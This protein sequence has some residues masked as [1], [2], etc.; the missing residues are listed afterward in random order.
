MFLHIAICD[1]DPEVSEKIKSYID[2][3]QIA[4]DHD[5]HIDLFADG[6]SLLSSENP[7]EYSLIFLDVE[8]PILSGIETARIIRDTITTSSKVIFVSNYPKYMQSSFSVHPYQYLQKPISEN[9]IFDVLNS[10]IRDIERERIYI[11]FTLPDLSLRTIN[12]HELLY[13]ESDDS[14][15]R[16]M[17]VHSTTSTFPAKGVLTDFSNKLHGMQFVRCHKSFLVN[18]FHIHYLNNQDLFL[19]TGASIPIG[20]SYGPEVRNK[21]S[22]VI[23]HIDKE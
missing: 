3:Y 12:L 4:F 20:R 5:F 23:F 19:D 13:I 6:T 7:S 14:R 18:L 11:T 10:A 21:L 22:S 15:K 8:M 1:D 2:N 16:T 9:D 17:I